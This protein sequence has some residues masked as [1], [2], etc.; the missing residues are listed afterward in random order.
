LTKEASFAIFLVFLTAATVIICPRTAVAE[1]GTWTVDDDGPADFQRIQD[2]INAAASGD[3]IFVRSGVYY[4]HVIVN[5]PVAL[6]GENKETTVIDAF[7]V[8][9]ACVI[10]SDNVN[11]TGFTVT[12]TGKIWGPPVSEKYP[13]SCILANSVLNVRVEGNVLTDAAVGLWISNSSYVSVVSNIF[14]GSVYAGIVGYASSNISIQRN[15]VEHSGLMGILLDAGSVYSDVS[16]NV[17][18]SNLEGLELK[19]GS[20]ASQ[21]E[22]NMF[23]SNGVSIVLNDAGSEF[24]SSRNT[25][26]NNSM[27]GNERNLVV[28]GS[29]I[30]SFMQNID[31]SNLIDGRKVYYLTNLYDYII[32]PWS[33]P[34]LGYLAVI[35]STSVSVKDISIP[36]NGDGMLL[37][38]SVWCGLTNLTISG[39]RG[40]LTWGGLTI[41][42]SGIVTVRNSHFSNNS[43]GLAFQDSDWNVICSNSFIANDRN[44]VSDFAG[45]FSN[46]SSGHYSQNTWDNGIEGNYWSDYH[47]PDA[48]KDGIGDTPHIIDANNTDYR[49][50]ILVWADRTPPTIGIQ[51]P[52]ELHSPGYIVLVSSLT[53]VWNA[54]D[55]LTAIS[56]YEIRLDDGLWTKVGFTPPYTTFAEFTFVDLSDGLHTVDIRAADYAGNVRQERYGFIVYALLF[57]V[58]VV[59]IIVAVIVLA[60]AALFSRRRRFFPRGR[61]VTH[62][63]VR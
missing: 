59:V 26:R 49:P 15:T 2:A 32:A 10:D 22:R 7:G 44:V 35:N 45:P 60:S 8:G 21:I 46:L 6:T 17:L 54:W 30:D 42:S 5:K 29:N 9:T 4:E 52:Y 11:V 20:T 31:S 13:D 57:R 34:N 51:S 1:P 55:D 38:Y 36:R 48:D 47:G 16:D 37:A 12:N 53:I 28:W 19:A 43:Y 39:N 50:L 18:T 25:F 62:R 3:S 41:C 61:K 23:S 33:C 14:T 24:V 58:V 63:L 40:P 56:Y 27:S